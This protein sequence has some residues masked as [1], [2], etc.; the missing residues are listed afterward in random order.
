MKF[1]HLHSFKIAII[2]SVFASTAA[3]AQGPGQNGHGG[4][5]FNG[6]GPG[7]N[8]GPGNNNGPGN[9]HGPGNNNGPGFNNGPSPGNNN[10]P[11]F[12]NPPPPPPPAPIQVYSLDNSPR[13]PQSGRLFNE[14]SNTDEVCQALGY[15]NGV[16][17]SLV[18][19]ESQYNSQQDTTYIDANGNRSVTTGYGIWK[20][21]CR[22]N[23]QVAPPIQNQI[24]S[25]TL[26]SPRNPRTGRL[27]NEGSNA[28]AV[29]Q[30]LGYLN[31][32]QNSLVTLSSQYNSQQDTDLI[33]QGGYDQVTMG[34]GIWTLT[35]RGYNQP[36]NTYIPQTSELDSPRD[37]YPGRL[38]NENSNAD[39]TCRVLG[40]L[41]G[42]QGA[43]VALESQYNSQQ[44][45]TYVDQ[46]GNR[47]VTEGYGIWKLFCRK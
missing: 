40:Y 8:H 46:N 2:A 47:S 37:P 19:L 27:F 38:F 36:A 4:N 35:C 22:G 25:F 15:L 26:S 9:H 44:D 16:E 11:G 24:Q 6:N 10:G 21:S 45:T 39:A 28:D 1:S 5:G 43:T 13:D 3:F 33:S 42:V 18:A 14:N 17:G 30:F 34:Y 12:N 23:E 20:I 7:F 32:D 41:N 31:G 29:C